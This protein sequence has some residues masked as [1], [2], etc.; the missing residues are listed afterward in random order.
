VFTHFTKLFAHSRDSITHFLEWMTRV[1]ARGA[2]ARLSRGHVTPLGWLAARLRAHERKSAR[3]SGWHG[4]AWLDRVRGT[5]RRVGSCLAQSNHGW[6]VQVMNNVCIYIYIG[7]QIPYQPLK[8]S[9]GPC[10][11]LKLK[12]H[13][14][15]LSYFS[16][17]IHLLPSNL[18]RN[19]I[20]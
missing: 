7:E 10:Q 9:Q 4:P 13:M 11:P 19:R 16:F 14:S 20:Q 8:K 18:R 15:H 5:E 12:F 17:L 1:Q 3:G 6:L 2:R